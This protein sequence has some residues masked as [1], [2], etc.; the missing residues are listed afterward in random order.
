MDDS[1]IHRAFDLLR[2]GKSD[3]ATLLLSEIVSGP[4]G[5]EDSRSVVTAHFLL[6]F[7]ASQTYW[8]AG[9]PGAERTIPPEVH[10]QVIQHITAFLDD[11]DRDRC[12][13]TD[14]EGT[15]LTFGEPNVFEGKLLGNGE[16][17]LFSGWTEAFSR[18]AV[19]PDFGKQT[20]PYRDD[21]SFALD[22]RS[23]AFHLSGRPFEA[24]RDLQT[25][26]KR[27]LWSD[28]ANELYGVVS[29][30]YPNRPDD[31]RVSHLQG[32]IGWLLFDAGE[33]A[34]AADYLA[35]CHAAMRPDDERAMQDD[36]SPE[37]AK[38]RTWYD[39]VCGGYEATATHAFWE[40]GDWS[41]GGLTPSQSLHRGSDGFLLRLALSLSVNN[42]Y[43]DA[44][45]HAESCVTIS[46][47]WY[48]AVTLRDALKDEPHL[49]M[50][51]ARNILD[52]FRSDKE[53]G[54]G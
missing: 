13:V 18:W 48:E 17:R 40:I 8:R 51:V 30:Y 12:L 19:F 26:L 16:L 53:H 10:E 52:G 31:P 37:E 32:W 47:S 50:D 44:R 43:A 29:E 38:L 42:R 4:S 25:A 27:S 41:D 1:R 39:F 22:R 49:V 23:L 11:S 46:P 34:E 33:Y 5:S 21:I 15:R 54:R 6:G 9:S 45:R 35:A 20:A 28:R 7:A 36:I 3:E 2:D 24:A 14:E